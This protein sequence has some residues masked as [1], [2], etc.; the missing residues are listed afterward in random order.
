MPH[1]AYCRVFNNVLMRDEVSV[2]LVWLTLKLCE[3]KI[4]NRV[5]GSSP[6]LMYDGCMVKKHLILK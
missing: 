3:R 6:T 4:R 5:V 1:A 2:H